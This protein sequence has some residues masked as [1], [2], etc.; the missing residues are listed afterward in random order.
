MA[1]AFLECVA[2][3]ALQHDKYQIREKIWENK[4][5]IALNLQKTITILCLVYIAIEVGR[6]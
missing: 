6:K 4:N 1:F 2:D 5:E 3:S